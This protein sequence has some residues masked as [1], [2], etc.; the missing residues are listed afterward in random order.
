MSYH[1]LTAADGRFAPQAGA[2]QRLT[3][4]VQLAAINV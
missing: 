2:E 4:R 3:G 1:D